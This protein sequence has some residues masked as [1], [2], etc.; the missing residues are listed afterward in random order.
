MGMDFSKSAVSRQLYPTFA[1]Y[2]RRYAPFTSFGGANPFGLGQR[3]DGDERTSA[4]TSLKASARTYGYVMFNQTGVIYNFAGSTG[5]T[6]HTFLWGDAFAYAKVDSTVVDYVLLHGKN[7]FVFSANTAGSDPLVPLSPDINTFITAR[8]DYSRPRYL[9]V[10]GSAS[11]DNFP[12]LEVFLVCMPS[13]HSAV[14]ID[15]RTTGGRDIGPVTRL[16]GASKDHSLGTFDLDWHLDDKGLAQYDIIAAP[17][18][19]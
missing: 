5:T 2:F 12:N 15:G 8:V 7:S 13:R 1:L 10:A 11:G 18:T 9:R 16:W 19:L 14:L 3:F 17:T 4:S 6:V